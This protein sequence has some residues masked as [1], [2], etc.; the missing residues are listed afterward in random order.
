MTILN[1]PV[2]L[3]KIPRTHMNRQPRMLIFSELKV[4]QQPRIMEV[5]LL[6]L[7]KACPNLLARRRV[8]RKIWRWIEEEFGINFP[9]L[10]LLGRY[11]EE[12]GMTIRTIV[13]PM[14][15]RRLEIIKMHLFRKQVMSQLVMVI[16]LKHMTSSMT[17]TVFLK[18]L[19]SCI[20]II[21][22]KNRMESGM[23]LQ[24]HMTSGRAM[25]IFQK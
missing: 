5:I 9:I 20:A 18:C 15:G 14:R 10:L 7:L 23:I 21:I 16:F 13:H 6:V 4:Q 12:I 8:G 17:I 3:L 1:Q 22:F 2:V 19:K 11:P 24:K 25:I